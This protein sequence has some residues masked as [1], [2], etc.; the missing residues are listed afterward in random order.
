MKLLIDNQLPEALG[1]YLTENGFECQ[2]VRRIGLRMASDEA[3]WNHARTQGMAILT[4][5]EDFVELASRLGSIPPQVVWIRFGNT[6]KHALL[7]AF[8]PLLPTL[9]QAL[10]EGHAVIELRS[11]S[12]LP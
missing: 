7:A 12:A 3:I 9:R 2:H 1:R 5:D 11:G 10:A 6:R 4:L 8:E